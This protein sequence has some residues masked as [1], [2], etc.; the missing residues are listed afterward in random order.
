[1]NIVELIIVDDG[2]LY[3]I[4]HVVAASGLSSDDI[5]DLIESGAIASASESAPHRFDSHQVL[6]IQ[7]ARRLRDDF[8]LDRHGLALVLTLLQRISVLEAQLNDVKAKGGH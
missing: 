1:M 5:E 2:A 8:Q 3:S 4:E 6:T 7:A